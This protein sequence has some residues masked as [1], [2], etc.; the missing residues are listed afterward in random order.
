MQSC[1]GG[2]RVRRILTG[3]LV[4]LAGVIC[5]TGTLAVSITALRCHSAGVVMAQSP[6]PLENSSGCTK[7]HAEAVD[8]FSRS[9]MAHS[10]RFAGRE[11]AGIVKIPGTTITMSSKEGGSWQ[12]L[13]S[14]GTSIEY[15]VDYVI[16][17]GTHAAGYIV[18]L[19]DHLFQ[20]PVAFYRR[21]GAYGLAPGYE[22]GADPD[23]TRPVATGCV[24]CHA[25]SFNQIPGTINQ[26]SV[27]PF[28][29][30]A[31]GCER[32][33]GSANAHLQK[34]TAGNIVSPARLEPAARDSV[35]EQCHLIGAARVL[36]PGKQ[37]TDFQ[38][39][40]RLEDTF[41]I[42]RTVLP[43]EAQ[44]EFKVISH[45]EQLALSQCKRSSGGKMWCGTCHD[46]HNEPTE[47]V[48]YYRERCLLCHA[49]TR[50]SSSHPSRTSNCIGCHMPQRATDDGGHTVF[51][52]HRIQR[53]P[54]NAPAAQSDS[55]A[56][57]REPPSGLATRNLGIASIEVGTNQRSPKQIVSGYRMLTSIQQDF[58]HDS[59]MY[60]SMGS[61]LYLGKQYDEAARAFELALLY[62]LAQAY[63]ASGKL[64]L[65][66]PHLEKALQIDPL[67][68]SAAKL[69][70]ELYSRAGEPAKAEDVSRR[71][72]VLI[73]TKAT[74]K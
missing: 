19:G 41:T 33:H 30:L 42:Y 49:T 62:D 18:D 73:Q 26:Y 39:G 48:A 34:P 54:A 17:S 37:F 50:F 22:A 47:A 8:G 5:F 70:M 24:F 31:I 3:V 6:A 53:R 7:C 46:P 32:C 51:T 64:E 20:S 72:S 67:N 74:D 9:R 52:D 2:Q 35:C 55:I 45:S 10:V 1:L 14:G 43:A 58:P 57:W 28:T 23:Y 38:P 25:G 56:A 15:H 11:P 40:Q 29:H 69:L 60:N 4:R 65:A 44:G 16:G 61:A 59:E 27:P 71:I 12:R 63:Q 36:N 13:E 21:R 66:Q 68:L